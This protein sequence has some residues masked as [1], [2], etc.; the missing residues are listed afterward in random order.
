MRKLGLE[1]KNG[2]SIGDG[3]RL[4]RS[5]AELTEARSNW[6]KLLI[7]AKEK[8]AGNVFVQLISQAPLF[9]VEYTISFDNDVVMSDCVE[10]LTDAFFLRYIV[11]A[12]EVDE[13]IDDL[14][15]VDRS[16]YL[17]T[18]ITFHGKDVVLNKEYILYEIPD[19]WKNSYSHLEFDNLSVELRA[20]DDF[21]IVPRIH[22]MRGRV[23]IKESEVFDGEFLG[24]KDDD[25]K[26]LL[27]C[28]QDIA[29]NVVKELFKY[30]EELHPED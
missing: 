22:L 14:E 8:G 15:E 2:V 26:V 19:N 1:D 23:A 29:Y 25:Y 17:L 12:M 21:V 7:R 24:E 18:G 30:N 27:A 13:Q 3:S 16:G 5:L 20:A 9:R 4:S 6:D 28:H 10:P 11:L